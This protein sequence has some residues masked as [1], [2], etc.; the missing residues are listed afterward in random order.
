MV[1]LFY[2]KKEEDFLYFR[3]FIKIGDSDMC[4]IGFLWIELRKLKSLPPLQKQRDSVILIG[5]SERDFQCLA[6]G[7]HLRVKRESGEKP[8]RSGHCKQGVRL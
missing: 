3:C 7:I 1:T 5:E 6:D 8:E 4:I 2:I